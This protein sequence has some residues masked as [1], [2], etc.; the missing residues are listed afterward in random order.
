MRA[1]G[2]MRTSGWYRIKVDGVWQF[3]RYDQE[4]GM[5]YVTRYR[6]GLYAD[7]I[8]QVDETPINPEPPKK[9]IEEKLKRYDVI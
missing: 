7:E 8:E 2:F 4:D 5:W 3:G 1:S 6:F 9:D